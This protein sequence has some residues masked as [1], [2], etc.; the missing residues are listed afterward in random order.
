M[1]LLLERL[2][3]IYLAR[4]AA[5]FST[6]P[7]VEEVAALLLV[8]GTLDL[9]KDSIGFGEYITIIPIFV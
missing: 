1:R 8:L 3:Y 5:Y 4:I 7:N 2:A 9:E 6:G